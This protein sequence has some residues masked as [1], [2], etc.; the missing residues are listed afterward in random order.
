MNLRRVL[1]TAKRSAYETHALDQ[2]DPRFLELVDARHPDVRLILQSHDEH[3][4]TLETV[5]KTL[6]RRGVSVD[7]LDR[8]AAFD[9]SGYDLVITVG[10]DGTFISA[11]HAVQSRPM[12]GVN[13][14]PR[15][16][17]GFFCGATRRT[18]D[19]MLDRAIRDTLPVTTFQ[20][21]R[22]LLDDVA[23][24]EPALNDVLFA[25]ENPA[26]MARYQL[27]VR[28]IH[29]EQKS[30]GVW[31]SPPAGSR[32]AIGSAGGRKLPLESRRFQFVVREPYLGRARA[33]R[34]RKG[35]LGEEDVLEIEN[36]FGHA[37]VF[38]DGPLVARPVP[39][40]AVIRIALSDRPLRVLGFRHP[41]GARRPASRRKRRASR[42]AI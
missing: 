23:L 32:A 17:V 5:E 39:F 38:V 18:F 28:G 6:E 26:A 29:E 42:R 10:G 21:L 15:D 27:S 40:G 35:V 22:V 12:L 31:V 33:Y 16:S 19:R 2:P 36:H 7:R 37:R 4:L 9:D 24:P 14:A 41:E 20:R 34:L 8:G 11:S 30:S 25:H 13:S 1:L 3:H